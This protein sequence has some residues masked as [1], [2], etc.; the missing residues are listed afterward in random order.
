MASKIYG[1]FSYY[2]LVE[3]CPKDSEE[4][5]RKIRK[6]CSHISGK[7]GSSGYNNFRVNFFELGNVHISYQQK[8]GI[9]NPSLS[10]P[11][12]Q[13]SIVLFWFLS[14]QHF[15]IPPQGIYGGVNHC[16]QIS[17]TFM[18]N[19]IVFVKIS[20]IF[21]GLKWS[22]QEWSSCLLRVCWIRTQE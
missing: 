5:N 9:L 15:H 12:Q 3:V 13:F 22:R 14:S 11:C 18:R 19:S 16:W 2:I 20:V 21:K 8:Y 17:S 1:E 4:K 6:I 10:P 7:T